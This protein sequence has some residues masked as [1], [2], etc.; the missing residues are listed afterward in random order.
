MPDIE[1]I[2]VFEEEIHEFQVSTIH[3]C[4]EQAAEELK[5]PIG[6]YI[7][8]KTGE[9]LNEHTKIE[10]IGECLPRY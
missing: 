9:I 4:S 7:T 1:G 8:I 6:S 2:E 3:V 10:N 5:K